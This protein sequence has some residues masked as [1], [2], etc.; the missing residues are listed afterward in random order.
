M[1]HAITRA[2]SPGLARCE[3]THLERKQIDLAL[4]RDQHDAHEQAGIHD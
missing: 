1:L 3:L 2:V 4:A